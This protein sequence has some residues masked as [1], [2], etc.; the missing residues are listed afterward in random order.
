MECNIY[1]A[2]EIKQNLQCP[3]AGTSGIYAL[4][5]NNQVIY[6]GQSTNLRARI[7]AHLKAESR[8]KDLFKTRK[9]HECATYK[10]QKER[11][12]FIRDNY[13][14][15]YYLYIPAGATE[16]NTL[17]EYYIAKY[18]PRFNYAGVYSKYSGVERYIA[19]TANTKGD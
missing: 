14:D 1:K 13:D 15:I 17:E 7:M 5:H 12:E 2:S 16:L 3:P 10:M 8:L 18:K 4:I 11:Y 9:N 6:V 19:G